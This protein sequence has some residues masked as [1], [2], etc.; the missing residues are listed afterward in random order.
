MVKSSVKRRRRLV[1]NIETFLATVISIGSSVVIA[2]FFIS[3]GPEKISEKKNSDDMDEDITKSE[4][5]TDY[6]DHK[7]KKNQIALL[8]I[9]VLLTIAALTN[10]NTDRHKEAIESRLQ[11]ATQ[12]GGVSASDNEWE[13]AGSTLGMMFQVHL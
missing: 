6:K 9:G 7:M 13:N 1:S 8:I 10:P 3:K 11:K 2:N 4:K 12:Q 5:L